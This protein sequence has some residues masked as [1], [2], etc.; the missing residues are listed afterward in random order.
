[1]I[2]PN[3]HESIKSVATWKLLII[4]GFGLVCLL[5]G[6]SSMSLLIMALGVGLLFIAYEYSHPAKCS[7]CG[8]KIMNSHP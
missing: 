6:L 3:C 2:C 5:Q 7:K 4:A 8:T 1:M